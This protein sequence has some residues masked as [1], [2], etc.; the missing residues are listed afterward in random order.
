[1]ENPSILKPNTFGITSSL[2]ESIADANNL[3]KRTLIMF[4]HLQG[5]KNHHLN[6]SVGLIFSHSSGQLRASSTANQR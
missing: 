3:Q 4:N 1:V 2:N 6:P 5:L